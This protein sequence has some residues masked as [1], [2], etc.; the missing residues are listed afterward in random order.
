MQVQNLKS[1]IKRPM[2][3]PEFLRQTRTGRQKVKELLIG[4]YN[5]K[6]IKELF[7]YEVVETK[8]QRD[9]SWIPGHIRLPL[10]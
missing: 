10:I 5:E 9:T 6:G 3:W 4:S 2:K 1:G 7:Q 8:A